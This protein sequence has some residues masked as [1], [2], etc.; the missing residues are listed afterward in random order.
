MAQAFRIWLSGLVVLAAASVRGA[1]EDA[2]TGLAVAPG[3]E[4]VRAHCGAC[5]SYRLVTSQRGDEAFWR[6]TIRWMQRT[7]NLW[8]IAG[9]EEARIVGYLAANYAETDWGRR[10]LLSPLLMP[11]DLTPD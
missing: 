9:E 1:E 4:S 7:Q 6:D 10:P 8:P 11:G 5:H 2:A 3:W